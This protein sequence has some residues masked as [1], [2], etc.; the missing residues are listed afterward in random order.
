MKRD[1]TIRVYDYINHPYETVREK[2]SAEA[3]EVFRSST[4]IAA[5]RAKSLASGQHVNFA[6]IEVGS[7]ISV[8]IKAVEDEPKTVSSP[9]WTRIR[10]EWESGGLP[11]LFPFMRAELSV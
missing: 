6:G 9:Q 10:L 8:L 11:R 3:L 1:K 7:D 2:L 4:K 5:L